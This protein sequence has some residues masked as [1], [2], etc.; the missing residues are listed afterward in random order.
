MK[1]KIK[2]PKQR[3]FVYTAVIWSGAHVNTTPTKKGKQ[4][5]VDRKQKQKGWSTDD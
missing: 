3:D 1:N 5:K 4:V 2:K